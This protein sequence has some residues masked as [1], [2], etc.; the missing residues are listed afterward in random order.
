MRN[1]RREKRVYKPVTD[2]TG[3]KMLGYVMRPYGN[4]I[5]SGLFSIILHLVLKVSQAKYNI[6]C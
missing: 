6:Q 2:F 4:K 5:K 1:N 3:H